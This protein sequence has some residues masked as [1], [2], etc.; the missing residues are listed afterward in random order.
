MEDLATLIK[1][2]KVLD[3]YM[4]LQGLRFLQRLLE[5]QLQQWNIYLTFVANE[6]RLLDRIKD[7]VIRASSSL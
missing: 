6:P 5:A 2:E 3:D 4:H 7:R 1:T